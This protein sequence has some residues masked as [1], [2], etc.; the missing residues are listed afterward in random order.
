MTDA[1]KTLKKFDEIDYIEVF[2]L[3]WEHLIPGQKHGCTVFDMKKNV[4]YGDSSSSYIDC[5]P[6]DE[7]TLIQIEK[8]VFSEIPNN[9]VLDDDELKEMKIMQINVY[10]YCKQKNINFTER[11]YES[12]LTNYQQNEYPEVMQEGEEKIRRYFK[13]R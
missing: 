8:D 4:L 3:A 5:D 13:N 10:E 9:W 6:E 12:L 1:E 2:D 7:I 11:A